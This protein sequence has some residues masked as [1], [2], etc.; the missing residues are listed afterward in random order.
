MHKIQDKEFTMDD[1]STEHLIAQSKDRF[2]KIVGTLNGYRDIYVNWDEQDD[3]IQRAFNYDKKQVW[4]QMIQ[5]LPSSYNQTRNVMLNYEVLANIYKS[6]KDHKL[7]EWREFCKWIEK[8][9]YS[10]LII[11]FKIY[12]AVEYGKAHPEF[13]KKVNKIAASEKEEMTNL[14]GIFIESVLNGQLVP[15][16]G[17]VS[18]SNYDNT[19][20]NEEN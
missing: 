2:K 3:G 17:I 6:R 12:D 19:I 4:W 5:L 9:P 18:G 10:E 20:I 11:E 8:L 7:D 15:R 16:K 14:S 13:V 1:F